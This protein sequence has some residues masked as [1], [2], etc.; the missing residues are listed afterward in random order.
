MVTE[1]QARLLA[2]EFLQNA[3][4][5]KVPDALAI[6]T[7]TGNAHCWVVGYNTSE[8]IAS[9]NIRDTLAGGEPIIINRRTGFVRQGISG[10][11]VEDQLD[12]S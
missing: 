3:I 7:V 1:E 10:K 2:E 4:Q 12:E 6:T 11:P 9:G 8:F 5:V